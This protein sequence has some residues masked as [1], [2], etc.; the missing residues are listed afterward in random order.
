MKRIFLFAMVCVVALT[1]VASAQM[2]GSK[3]EWPYSSDPD[4]VIPYVGTPP[5]IDGVLDAGEKSNALHFWWGPSI[6]TLWG[7]TYGYTRGPDYGPDRVEVG[8]AGDLDNNLALGDGED[9]GEKATDADWFGH[10]YWAWDDDFLYVAAEVQDNVF[11]I[12]GD[13]GSGEWAF[14]TRDGFFLEADLANNGG[15]VPDVDEPKVYLHPMGLADTTYSMQAWWSYEGNEGDNHMYG[16]DP[17][18]FEG[19]LLVGGPVAGGYVIEAAVSWDLLFKR[20]PALRGMV[21]AGYKFNMTLICPDPDGGDGYGQTFWGRDYSNLG[22]MDWWPDFILGPLGAEGAT[23]VVNSTDDPGT[24]GDADVTL[25][26]A[27]DFASGR[28]IPS[29]GEVAQVTG[30]PASVFSDTIRFDPAVFPPP[31]GAPG[32]IFVVDAVL[33]ALDMGNDVIDGSDAGV[34]VDGSSTPQWSGGFAVTSDSNVIK[35]LQI[36]NF[37]AE[38]MFIN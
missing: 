18:F 27:M 7:D 8:A 25:R 12:I 26:E 33:P 10:F 17:G 30:T 31:P 11:D 28:A 6:I 3:H 15:T 1:T 14:W 22:D 9:P 5:I 16:E 13:P 19:S 34:V 35:G 20:A 38:G 2:M 24:P 29:G 23:I 36:L 21:Q 32:T 37:P 4:G